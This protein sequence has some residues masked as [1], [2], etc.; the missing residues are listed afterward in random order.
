[1]TKYTVTKNTAQKI[2][3]TKKHD[4]RLTNLDKVDINDLIKRREVYPKN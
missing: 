4:F 3:Q 2:S 1:M